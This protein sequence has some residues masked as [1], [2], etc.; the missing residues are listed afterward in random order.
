M[1][2]KVSAA[3]GK[4]QPKKKVWKAEDYATFLIPIE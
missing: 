3:V 1:S 4:T 2:K